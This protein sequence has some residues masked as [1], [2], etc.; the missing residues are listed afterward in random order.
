M[1]SNQENFQIIT[2]GE[3]NVGKTSLITRYTLNKFHTSHKSIED[4]SNINKLIVI[5]RRDIRL[6]IWGTAGQER[7]QLVTPNYYRGAL[8]VILVYDITEKQSF[9]TV[10]RWASKLSMQGEEGIQ[11]AIVGNK[12]DLEYKRDLPDATA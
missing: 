10:I 6:N 12:S 3:E 7:F 11:M 8:R 1:V 4:V 9:E 5:K 2:F